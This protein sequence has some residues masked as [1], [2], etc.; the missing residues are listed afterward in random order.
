MNKIYVLYYDFKSTAGNHA[1]MAHL[2][3]ALN[4]ELDNVVIVKHFPQEYKG[5]KYVGFIYAY[6]LLFYLMVKLKKND[7]VFFMEYL[8]GYFGYQDLI[9]KKLRRLGYKNQLAGLVHLSGSHL[10]EFYK[11]KLDI[12]ERINYLDQIWTFGS[13]LSIFFKSIGFDKEIITTF[14]YADTNYYK[15]SHV[16]DSDVSA[17]LNVIFVGNLKRNFTQLREIVLG[18]FESNI[19]F[20]ICTG[21]SKLDLGI[22]HLP[23]VKLYGFLEEKELL[24]LMQK[25]DVNLS[26]MED[27]IGSNAITTALAVGMVQVVSDVGS[28]RNYCDES[29]SFFCVDTKD[30]IESLHYLSLNNNKLLSMKASAFSRGQSLSISNF[31]KYFVLNLKVKKVH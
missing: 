17:P 29:N 24:V 28:I 23:N 31:I 21:R 16:R 9:S 11:S 5:G 14:H 10:L 18:A 6:C 3:R 25:G 8:S 30:F 2:A 13:S 1:G 20:H 4:T 15:P 7:K 19:N 22:E 26:V 27:T 12:L